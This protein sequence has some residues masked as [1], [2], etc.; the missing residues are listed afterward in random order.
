VAIY[1]KLNNAVVDFAQKSGLLDSEKAEAYKANKTYASFKRLIIDDISSNVLAPGTSSQSQVSAFKQR[2]GSDLAIIDP[3][4]SQIQ[5]ISETL[6][7]G[8]QNMIWQRL[9]A[10]GNDNVELAR[11]FEKV[12]T[13]RAVDPISGQ[14]SYPQMGKK[15]FVM[16]KTNGKP[17][18]YL[19]APEYVALAETLTPKE[20][21][22]MSF[23][24]VK[25]S[26]LFSRLTTSANPLFPLVNIPIDTI[27]AWMNTKTGFIPG[28]SQMRVI[29][30]MASYAKDKAAYSVKNLANRAIDIL[31]NMAI[32][33]KWFNGIKNIPI[34]DLSLEEQNLFAKYLAL[35]GSTQTLSAY[36]NMSPEDMIKAITEKNLIKKAVQNI[37]DFTLGILE[38]PSNASEYMTR[39]AEFK[40]AKDQGY[41]D[42]V[43]MYMAAHVSVPFIQSGTYGGQVGKTT[44][45]AVPYFHASIQVI[46][47]FAQT[48]KN[49]PVRTATIGAA[50]IAIKISQTLLTMALSDDDDKRMLAEQEPSEFGKYIYVPNKI[51]GGKGFTRIRFSNEFGTISAP[52]EMMILQNKGLAHYGFK[53]Y[54]D[55]TTIAVPQ[56]FNIFKPVEAA[57]AYAPQIVKPLLETGFNVRTYPNVRPIVPYGI[58][59]KS[60]MN[61]YNQYTTETSKYL[62]KLMGLSPMKIDYFMKAQ[63]GKVPDMLVRKIEQKWF[64]KEDKSRS[65][66]F[67]QEE[68]YVLAGKNYTDFYEKNKYYQ[69]LYNDIH[70]RKHKGEFTQEQLEIIENHKIFD[71][72]EDKIKQM[73]EKVN[74]NIEIPEYLKQSAFELLI[75]LNSSD[76]PYLLNDKYIKFKNDYYRAFP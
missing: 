26:G 34:K 5:F 11:R 41:S 36:Q 40:R 6:N 73:R 14:I 58:S 15:G 7:K 31:H 69:E 25:A 38:M 47:K 30:Q 65:Q 4:Y 61:Q 18:F 22:T 13:I 75:E 39:F 3:I 45:R 71:K 72:T 24:L 19:A 49:D 33:G 48:A 10:L 44:V 42:D 53:D 1:D 16:V 2:S 76:K 62:G 63:F 17:S 64:D 35:G 21:E 52:I 68:Q 60:P 55:A 8:M 56:Q 27:S 20:L 66:I 28:W 59:F 32:I 46:S 51:F 9:A 43:A 37:D 57:W 23:V 74:A 54:L 29:P 50:L 70:V 67:L 12:E